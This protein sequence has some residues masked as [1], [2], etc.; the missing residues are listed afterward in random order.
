MYVYAKLGQLQKTTCLHA[1]LWTSVFYF[2]GA[3]IHLKNHC[4]LSV[5]PKDRFLVDY[6][7]E[8]TSFSGS[9]SPLFT[10]Q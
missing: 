4:K 5:K 3:W 1:Y 2:C 8:S 6:L 10:P 9:Q 7:S